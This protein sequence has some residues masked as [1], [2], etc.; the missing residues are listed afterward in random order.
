MSPGRTFAQQ[1]GVSKPAVSQSLKG[2]DDVVVVDGREVS[3]ARLAVARAVRMQRSIFGNIFLARC[4]AGW[5][6]RGS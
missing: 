6:S 3:E 1:Q 5:W 4:V 2:A